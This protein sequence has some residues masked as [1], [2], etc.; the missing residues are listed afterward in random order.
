V[1]D[2]ARNSLSKLRPCLCYA[3]AMTRFPS[4]R[5]ENAAGQAVTEDDLRGRPA[6]VYLG[7]HPG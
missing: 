7:R 3:W 2:A 6:V 4:F 5:L 1:R